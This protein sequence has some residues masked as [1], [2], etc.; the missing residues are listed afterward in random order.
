MCQDHGNKGE[1]YGFDGGKKVKGRKRHI[2]VD[3]QGLLIGVLVTEANA[4]ERL[5]AIVVLDEAKEKLA[6]LQV[7]WV[8]QGY[9]GQNFANAV[10]QVCGEPKYRTKV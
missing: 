2:V 8:D 5:G 7:I 3:S 9:S 6:K 4:S 10:Q 1:V